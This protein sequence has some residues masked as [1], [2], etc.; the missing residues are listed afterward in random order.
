MLDIQP[1]E[2]WSLKVEQASANADAIVFLLGPVAS[3]S[4]QLQAEWQAVLRNDWDAKKLM[5][6][7]LLGGQSPSQLPKFL[8]NTHPIVATNFDQPVAQIEYVIQ[9]PNEIRVSGV[10]ETSRAEQRNRLEDLKTFAE[11]LKS[12]AEPDGST[13]SLS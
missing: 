3:A 12:G 2:S 4:P 1:G 9:S 13:I 11:A 8:A 6:P 5:I 10:S 7:V